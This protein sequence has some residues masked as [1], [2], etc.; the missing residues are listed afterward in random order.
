MI[1][2]SWAARAAEKEGVPLA[3]ELKPDVVVI[4]LD[5]PDLAGL[6]AMSIL[7][8]QLPGTGIIGMTVFDSRYY[9][10]GALSAGADAFVSK[11][12]LDKNLAVV[13]RRLADLRKRRPAS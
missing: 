11:G 6:Q 4:D 12:E 2:T 13:I 8:H 3:Q 10:N 9:Y 5:M 1:S 7:R